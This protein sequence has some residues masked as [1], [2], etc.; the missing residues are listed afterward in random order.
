MPNFKEYNEFVKLVQYRTGSGE[1]F[2]VG[3]RPDGR[4]NTSC[5]RCSSE[6]YLSKEVDKVH[7]SRLRLCDCR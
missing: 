4:N 2:V 6:V 1:V 3:E 5:I 7:G